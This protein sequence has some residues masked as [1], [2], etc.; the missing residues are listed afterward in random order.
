[1]MLFSITA[2]SQIEIVENFDDIPNNQLP[3][4][5]VEDPVNGF[6]VSTSSIIGCGS[7]YV[8]QGHVTT[9]TTSTLTT[10]NYLGI[11]NGTNLTV[12]FSYNV[13]GQ[14]SQF[15][16]PQFT[17]PATAWGSIVVEYSTDG[18]DNWT[19]ITTITDADFT[20]TS[21]NSC[22]SSGEIS[23]GVIPNGSDFQLRFSITTDNIENFAQWFVIDD[24]SITQVATAEPNCDSVLT[25][26]INGDTDALPDMTMEWEAATGLPTGY[27][28]SVGTTS[29]GTDIV[30]AATTSETS[31]ALTGLDWNTQYFVNVVPFNGIGS[32]SGCTEESFTT[33][34]EPIIGASCQTAHQVTTFPYLAIDDTNNYE[35]AYDSSPCS[36]TY[37][38]GKDVFYQITPANDMSI[39]IDVT[40][41]DNNGA[42]I[43]VVEGCIDTATNCVDYVGSFSGDTR[44]LSEVVLFEGNTYFIVLSNS[45]ST[46]TYNYNILI[47][48]NSCVDPSMSLTPTEDCGNGQFNVDVD[49]TYLGD[50][51]SLTLADDQGNIYPSAI[52]STGTVSMGPYASGLTVNFSLTNNQDNTCFYNDSAYWYCTPTNDEC[53]GAIALTV[54]TDDTC[55]NV[56]AGSNAGA[57]E[58]AGNTGVCNAGNANDV[59]YSFVATQE[60]M[61]LEYLNI[62]AAIGSG[63]TLQATELLSGTCGTLTS[64]D[65]RT[66]DYIT[67]GGLTIG[68]TYYIRN[69][70]NLSGEYAQNYDI[71]IRELPTAPS[72][73]DCA[74]AITIT[75]STDDTCANL[76]VGTT[77][78]AT[79]SVDNACT[80]TT[81]S[82][83]D[84]WYV[85]TPT[86]T[87]FF[88]FSL[89]RLQTSPSTYY[90]I[91]S[92]SCGA[93]TEVSSSCTS[94]SDAIYNLDMGQTYYVQVRSSQ[95]DPGINFELCIVDLPPAAA[96]SDCSSPIT[97]LESP[98]SSGSNRITGDLDNAYY[99]PE[100]ACSSTYESVWYEFTPAQTGTYH[101][102]LIR[103]SGSAYYT[104]YDSNDC[105]GGLDYLGGDINSCFESGTDTGPVVAG[106]TYL[107]SIQASSAASFEFFTYPDATLSVGSNEYEESFSY[108]PNPVEDNLT[109]EARNTISNVTVHNMLGQKVQEITPNG[110]NTTINM[111]EMNKGVYFVTV[112]INNS[113]KTI[114]VIKR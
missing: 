93:L 80:S 55:T 31:Y 98:D 1:M 84:V 108:Y 7:R 20:F 33:R 66:G 100:G 112:T 12:S 19:N 110:V 30:N 2:F 17:A 74:N 72:N 44:S 96:N 41:I 59:W 91:F 16:P 76:V 21:V 53:A 71:C 99:S 24:I 65:C 46:R 9:G 83:G 10:T 5:W 92:G 11:S 47:T 94:N 51:T 32:A 49:V 79:T 15:P 75:A 14:V 52:T 105:A 34:T 106:T 101:F 28:V 18:G 61:V 67:Y 25:N 43:H 87:G 107:V 37:M 81:T 45:G 88:E 90:S 85:F 48:Q 97:L 109:I 27:T 62:V 111:N 64:L 78:G 3:A 82:Y 114:K 39:N 22:A 36:N 42:S 6:D 50:A 13:F 95:T 38:N 102:E 103:T 73:D 40:S 104:V 69:Y 29:G 60:T 4:G 54:N 70:T 8:T 113:Q 35:D 57:T 63:G 56:Y 86:E 89:N 23:A 68:N 77:I 58:S 26:P